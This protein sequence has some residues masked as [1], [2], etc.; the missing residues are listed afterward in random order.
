MSFPNTRSSLVSLANEAT[1]LATSTVYGDSDGPP[2]WV[3]CVADG[4]DTRAAAQ[5]TIE[6][7]DG[8][9]CSSLWAR[10]L[11]AIRELKETRGIM[12]PVRVFCRTDAPP[13]DVVQFDNRFNMQRALWLEA[14]HS[15]DPAQRVHALCMLADLS[16]YR[17]QLP[18]FQ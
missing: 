12:H 16:Q 18:T 10:V 14:E 13:K 9:C 17:G 2:L 7:A 11:S 5:L 1:L 6:R 15:A 4:T 3:R 8:E